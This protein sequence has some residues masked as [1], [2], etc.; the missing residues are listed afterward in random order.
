MPSDCQSQLQMATGKD[1]VQ[2]ALTVQPVKSA[3]LFRSEVLVERQSQWLGTVLL[4]PQPSHR[5]FVLFATLA[6]AAVVGLL[7]TANFTRTARISGWLM[8][9]EGLVRVFAPRPGVVTAL[10][11]KEGVEVRKGDRLM[12][13][14]GELQSAALGAVQAE[15]ARSLRWRRQNLLE[16]RHQQ[17]RLLAQQQRALASRISVLRSEQAQIE[18]EITLLQARVGIAARAVELHRRL[19]DQGFVSDMKLQQVEAEKLEQDARL[20]ALERQQIT[21]RRDLITLESELQE[22]P[23]RAKKEMA[24]TGRSIAEVE[25]DL[26]QA[27]AQRE[28]VV[29]A[30]QD[31]VVTSI[32]AEPGGNAS[33]AGPLLSIVPAGTILE[34]HLYSPSRSVG[35]VRPGQPVLLRY[36]AYPYQKFGHYDGVVASISRSAVSPGELPPQLASL[37]GSREA[38][39][40]VYRITVTLM[41]Q[42]VTAYGERVPLQPGTQLEADVAIDK[43]R[44]IEWVLDP[45]YTLTGKW[46]G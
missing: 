43:R 8:P 20:G 45:L 14:S 32:L 12:A 46:Q 7:F 17:E 21:M 30:P 11:V 24:A 16:E 2:G 36:P 38:N 34:A 39:E 15:V 22:L 42:T 29:L 9:Q 19:R 5:C 26:A 28:I 25:Q 6:A 44:L 31:G 4:A 18:R 40:P 3:Q 33:V 13:L 41:S 35:F 10:Y 1:D 27:E 37:G 23:F